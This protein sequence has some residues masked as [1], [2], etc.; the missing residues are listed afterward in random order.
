M[1]KFEC[2]CGHNVYSESNDVQSIKWSDGHVC[3][4]IKIEREEANSDKQSRPTGSE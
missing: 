1:N 3:N 4:F 2:Y